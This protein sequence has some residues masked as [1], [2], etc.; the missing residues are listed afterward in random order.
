VAKG[1]DEPVR[2]APAPDEAEHK[3]PTPSAE[4]VAVRPSTG[5]KKPPRPASP[6]T[7]ERRHR[8]AG[9]ETED[10]SA[11][12]E[13]KP[14]TPRRR[15]GEASQPLGQL[16][17]TTDPAATVIFDSQPLGQTPLDHRNLPAGTHTLRLVGP[18][19]HAYRQVVDITSGKLTQLNLSLSSLASDEH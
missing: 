7:R 11:N 16:S 13:G 17:L 4:S 8:G 9:R 6:D 15:R 18:D 3:P 14:E 10:T 19:G 5:S 2:L 12:E 1:P